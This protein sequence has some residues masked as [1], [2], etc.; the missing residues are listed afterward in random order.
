VFDEETGL[1]YNLHRYYDAATGR[2]MQADPIGLEGGWNRFRYVGGNPLSYSDSLG[3]DADVTVY[4]YPGGLGHIGIGVNGGK[5]QGYYPNTNGSVN[6]MRYIFPG[7]PGAVLQDS[8]PQLGTPFTKS[9]RLPAS[10]EMAKGVLKSLNILEKSPGTYNLIYN[11][12]T[13]VM[14][15]IL[16]KNGFEIPSQ[17]TIHPETFIDAL[18]KWQRK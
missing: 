8:G 18:E 15:D 16:Y 17:T 10:D 5:P 7:V 11:N 3:L 4:F 1:S 2:Y 9:V 12:C 6:S 13:T 14:S